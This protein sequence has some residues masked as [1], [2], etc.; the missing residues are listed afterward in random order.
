[1]MAVNR[2]FGADSTTHDVLQGISL[3]GKRAVVTGASSGL[4][5]ETARALAQAGAEV[6]LAGRDAAR[7]EA[8]AQWVREQSG[9]PAVHAMTV[10]L[11]NM[12]SIRQFA[13]ELLQKFRKIQL[14]VN[15]AGVMACPL[16]RTADGFEMQFGTNHLGHFLLT[17][18]LLP[19]LKAGYP[20]RIVCLSSGGHKYSPVDFDDLNWEKRA[21]DKWLAYGQSKTANALHALA[22]DRRFRDQGVRAFAVHP[23][24]I[25]TD[26]SRHLTPDDFKAFESGEKRGQLKIKSVEAGAATSVWAATAPELKG[27]GGLYLEDCHIAEPVQ[28]GVQEHG[29]YAY[30][31]DPA[32]SDRLWR[33]SERLTG[34][35][36]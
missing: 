23:G 28:P 20:S 27:K 14:L 32:A 19:A 8:A 18:L 25:F 31:L 34:W 5:R 12:A 13:D 35:R 22:L 11:A 29:Y 10:D 4:G 21:Y 9:N 15:N 24:V 7:T 2:E 17:G 30:A 3:A 1:M 33:I 6:I 36:G 16:A 26:L